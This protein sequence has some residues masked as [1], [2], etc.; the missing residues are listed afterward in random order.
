LFIY[1]EI[2]DRLAEGSV[3]SNLGDAYSALGEKK[4]ARELFQDALVIFEAME[5]PN[6]EKVRGW[7]KE[8]DEK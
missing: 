8:L 4:K 5:S 6:A 1:R 3:L 2:G 7:L